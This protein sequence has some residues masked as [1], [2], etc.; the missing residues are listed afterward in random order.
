MSRLK[1]VCGLLV[2]TVSSSIGAG[3]ATRPSHFSLALPYP[4]KVPPF[5]AAS[6]LPY[7]RTE[8]LVT[9]ILDIDNEGQVTDVRAERQLDTAFARYAEAWMKSITFEKATFNGKKVQSRLP[10]IL[11]FRPTVRLP[12][13]YFPL[14]SSGAIV[15]E[16]LYF[17]AFGLNEIRLPQLKEFP[18]YFC[19]LEWSDT[20]MIF[21]FVLVRVELDELGRVVNTEEV[22]STFPAVTM[23]IMSAILW[24]EFSP[25]AVQGTPVPSEC[26]VLVSFFPQIDYPTQVWR[27]SHLDSLKL[28]ERLRVRLLPDTI[29]LM[30]KPLPTKV[31]GDEF[32]LTG[33]HVRFA[34]TVNVGLFIDSTGRATRWRFSKA[35]KEIQA[36]VREIAAQL[37][38]FPALDYQGRSHPF[39]GLVSFVFQGSSRIRIVY[40]WLPRNNSPGLR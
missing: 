29:G 28:L 12:D 4:Q 31:P 14:D 33:R 22:L 18:S 1:I 11:H 30:A 20:S 8:R 39:S 19:D 35:G 9:I 34:D 37:R 26:F 40:H 7:L 10:V 5:V 13:V 3:S 2:L 23:Q 25:A 15:E 6:N 38:F 36:A 24:A 32:T 17:S 16:D 21:K 27:Q